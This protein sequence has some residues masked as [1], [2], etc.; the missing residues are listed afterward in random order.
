MIYIVEHLES[1][2]I[3]ATLIDTSAGF[4]KFTT[5]IA[6]ENGDELQSETLTNSINYINE[7]CDNL[8]L[9]IV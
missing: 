3:E 7:F 9:I 2:T 8:N 4:I 5:T 6:A 1:D